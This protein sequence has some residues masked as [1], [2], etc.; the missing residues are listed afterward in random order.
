MPTKVRAE[1]TF[2]RA[3]MNWQRTSI[4][5]NGAHS[6]FTTACNSTSR[7]S[8]IIQ[9]T[10]DKIKP[11]T[12]RPFLYQTSSFNRRQLLIALVSL[13]TG[14]LNLTNMWPTYVKLATFKFE[15]CA[16]WCLL[17]L[18]TSPELLDAARGSIIATRFMQAC[19]PRVMKNF[20]VCKIHCHALGLLHRCKYDHI[21]PAISLSCY[22]TG[23]P[24]SNE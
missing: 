5:S 16:A 17:F 19:R 12:L 13:S 1:S 11:I 22:S 14:N 10:A 18:M 4:Y 23:Y 2:R 21:S 3:M 7:K 20:T 9:F 24:S 8:D 15:F 6:S